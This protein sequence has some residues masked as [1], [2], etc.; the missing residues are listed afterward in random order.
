MLVPIILGFLGLPTGGP[1]AY[2]RDE[3]DLGDATSKREYSP[4]QVVRLAG[5]LAAPTGYGPLLATAFSDPDR[6]VR[7]GDYSEITFKQL[8][9]ASL[10]PE[11]RKL[12]TG[13][14]VWI[15]GQFSG[16]NDRAFSLTRYKINCC[17]ADA[18]P[19]K[20]VIAIDYSQNKDGARLDP[21][22]LRNKWVRVS[23][24]M[25]FKERGHGA[26]IPMIVVTPTREEKESLDD[27]VKQ[28]EA[29]GNPYIN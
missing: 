20:S 5:F 3:G 9:E 13:R 29:P 16:D 1:Q 18:I 6:I 19:L 2:P 4:K 14:E 27:L 12:Y 8:E 25:Q 10:T 11:Q 7:K 28:I 24:I 15:T 21:G 17:G 22:K 26:F 23:G